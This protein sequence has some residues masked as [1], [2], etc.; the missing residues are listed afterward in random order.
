MTCRQCEKDMN[1]KFL[2]LNVNAALMDSTESWTL[3]AAKT[4]ISLSLTVNR[5][6]H[7]EDGGD[8][9]TPHEVDLFSK[10]TNHDNCSGLGDKQAE[11]YFCSKECLVEWFKEQIDVL[12]NP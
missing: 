2:V 1:A 5:H 7:A 4:R 11:E 12:P 9:D 3:P 6:V 8:I 10:M